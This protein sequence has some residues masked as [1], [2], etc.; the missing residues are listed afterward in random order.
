MPRHGTPAAQ[1]ERLLQSLGPEG[2]FELIKV[3]IAKSDENAAALS[4]ILHR[5]IKQN[6]KKLKQRKRSVL[7]SQSQN[8]NLE[9]TD[10]HN[11]KNVLNEPVICA[12]FYKYLKQRFCDENL[13][14]YR[15]LQQLEKGDTTPAA[16]L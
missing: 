14:F 11:I 2:F 1:V 13:L 8:I 16:Y 9:E 7:L 15:E 3:K 10:Y 6:E 5:E 12:A 4:T